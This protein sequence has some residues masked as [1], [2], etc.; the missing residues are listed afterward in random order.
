[1][2][3]CRVL[4]YS[5]LASLPAQLFATDL[6]L[7]DTGRNVRLILVGQGPLC[8]A[9]VVTPSSLVVTLKVSKATLTCGAKNQLIYVSQE[10]VLELVPERRLTQRR[11][12]SKVLLGL[13]GIA[14]FATIP[15]I[16]SDPESVLILGNFALPAIVVYAAWKA[17]PRRLDYLVMMTCP[18]RQHC[19][20]TSD[21]RVKLPGLIVPETPER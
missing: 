10:N 17:I 19:V 15:L 1:M 13:A 8:E 20:S 14:A 5:L 6:S 2:K 3:N 16:S 4:I 21:P 12:L 11:I 9:K 18:D 7:L